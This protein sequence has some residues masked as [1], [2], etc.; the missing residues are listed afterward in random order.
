[1][2]ALKEVARSIL[3]APRKKEYE[4]RLSYLSNTYDAY[5]LEQEKE[6]MDKTKKGEASTLTSLEFVLEEGM[7]TGDA[8]ILIFIGKDAVLSPTAK[9]EI[10]KAFEENPDGILLYCDED[11]VIC[12][13]AEWQGMKKKGVSVSKRS[14]PRLKPI[15]SPET[16]I[17]YFY[18]GNIVA[19]RRSALK[20]FSYAEGE[21][22]YDFMLRSNGR[23]GIFR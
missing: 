20:D 12:S 22:V 7:K 18:P 17:S 21:P 1:M 10:C 2:G 13:D 4:A 9:W 3:M 16:L 14:H 6:L 19:L 15:Y 23:T 11:S 8:D 5:M